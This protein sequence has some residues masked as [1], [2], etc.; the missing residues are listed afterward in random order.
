MP[1]WIEA[2]LNGPWSRTRQQRIPIS[3]AEIVA[4]GIAAAREGAAIIHVHAYDPAT[5]L[6]ND[7]PDAYAAIIEGI[8]AV[9]DVIVY[10]TIPFLQSADAFSSEAAVARFAAIE[11]LARRGLLEWGVVDPGSINLAILADAAKGK[12]GG[13]YL[14][15]GEHVKRGL[16]LAARHRFIPSYAIYEPGFLRLGA[17]LAR[18]VADCPTPFYRFMFSDAFSFGFGP[19]AYALDAYVRL[20]EQETPGSPW[21]IAGLGVDIRP[22][23]ADA[24]ARGGHVRV[25]LEDAP[26]GTEMGNAAWVTEAVSLV[27]KAGGRPATAAEIRRAHPR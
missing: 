24:V 20:L 3:V 8:R 2:A 11:A 19:H 13:L 18:G 10:P 14:N 23:I 17:A 7:D 27:R 22:L 12:A 25:G 21:M 1:V 9:A 5:G 4:D 15:P 26:F 16:E 6:Q